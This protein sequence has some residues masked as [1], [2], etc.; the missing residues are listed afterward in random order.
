M[1]PAKPF[2]EKLRD[3]AWLCGL[4]VAAIPVIYGYG[5]LNERVEN[6]GKLNERCE[7]IITVHLPDIEGRL[8][9]SET[10]QRF[11]HEALEKRVNESVSKSP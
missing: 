11:L 7:T 8:K 3:W 4:L 10:V 6:I 1:P 5:R 2:S 9:A